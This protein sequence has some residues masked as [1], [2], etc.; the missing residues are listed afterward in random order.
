WK[1]SDS[2]ATFGNKIAVFKDGIYTVNGVNSNANAAINANIKPRSFFALGENV[3]F[4]TSQGHFYVNTGNIAFVGME[5]RGSRNDGNNRIIQ[6][7]VK[8]DN[9][10]FWNLKFSNQTF[11]IDGHDNPSC[12]MF[13]NDNS[14]LQNVAMVD[15]ALLPTA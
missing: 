4:N 6:V 3:V 12:V 14:F 2:D 15:C 11:G 5:F 9:Y 1:N 7:S 10:L 13:Y 8:N